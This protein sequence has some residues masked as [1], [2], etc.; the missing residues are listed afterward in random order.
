MSEKSFLSVKE[1]FEKGNFIIPYYQRGFK[2]SLLTNEKGNTH[3]EQLLIDLK[4]DFK[5]GEVEYHLQGVTVQEKDKKIELVDGQQRTTSLFLILLYAYEKKLLKKDSFFYNNLNLEYAVRDEVN[6]WIKQ[7]KDNP[8]FSN[9][10]GYEDI[11]DIVAFNK[12]WDQIN[13]ELKEE[14]E[15]FFKYILNNVKLIYIV[16]NTEPTKVFSMMN[17]DKAIMTKTELVKATL[18]SEASRQAFSDL[19]TNENGDN[20]WQINHLRSHFAREWDSWLKWWN[21]NENH[22]FLNNVISKMNDEPE[23]SRL[24]RL[25]YFI[26]KSDE[27][28]LLEE[29]HLF[30]EYC[31]MI[32]DQDKDD[33]NKKIGAVETFEGLRNLQR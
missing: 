2:W 19:D 6:D 15:E 22:K 13:E 11:Q 23:I 12:A 25:Y 8:D 17:K 28:K 24:L 30:S 33:D 18:L 31:K 16:L 20:E 9:N 26:E 29:E 21:K 27:S 32:E 10:K 7:K 4:N 14:K 5:K 1:Y 3:L